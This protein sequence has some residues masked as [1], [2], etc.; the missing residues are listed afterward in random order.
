MPIKSYTLQEI[1]SQPETWRAALRILTTKIE[2]ID[3]FVKQVNF[4]QILVVGC[5]SSYYMA[6]SL[7][8]T[9][10][11]LTTNHAY[12]L[13]S[14]DVWL[15]PKQSFENRLLLI[16]IS[17]SGI[18]T[19]TLRALEQFRKWNDGAC[20]GITCSN[21]S[22]LAKNVDFSLVIPEGQEEGIAQTR[23]FTSMLLL[24]QGLTAILASNSEML[25]RMQILPTLLERMVKRAGDLPER[26]GGNIKLSN[27][28]FL[29]SG[30]LYG[31]ANEAML[32][33]KEI[34]LSNAEAFHFLEFRHGPISMVDENSLV[35]CFVSETALAEELAL[36]DEINQLGAST[37][38]MV[39]DASIFS[40]LKIDNIL[41]LASGLND[42]ERGALYLPIIHRLAYHRAL[43]KGLNPDRPRNLQM[44]VTL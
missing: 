8:S 1:T 2:A 26:I 32:K 33:V 13:P 10:S 27:L 11:H 6:Q 22:L 44:V 24:A 37:L 5:G 31:L 43:Q 41:E 7:A 39:D 21:N 23:S 25:D 36:I 19:E 4:E 20:V 18:T 14:S 34:S 9:I 35:T 29:G 28:F 42:W 15:F 40:D 30:P 12:A 16:C 38:V 17:R 3:K